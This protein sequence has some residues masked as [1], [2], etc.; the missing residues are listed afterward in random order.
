MSTAAQ[1]GR[2]LGLIGGLGLGATVHYYRA[3]VSAHEKAA[4]V[5]RLLI[6]H[7]DVQ[8]VYAAVTAKDFNGLARYLAQLVTQL[9][10]GGAEV[11]AIVAATP[12]HVLVQMSPFDDILR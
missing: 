11:T 2:C 6:A 1:E 7:A 9:A 5:P 8:R 10:A 3:L 12:H 4:R